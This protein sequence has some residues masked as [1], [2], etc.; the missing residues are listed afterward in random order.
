MQ[1]EGLCS[2]AFVQQNEIHR[3]E[4]ELADVKEKHDRLAKALCRTEVYALDRGIFACCGRCDCYMREGCTTLC[5]DSDCDASY[6][7]HCAAKVLKECICERSYCSA[8]I[9]VPNYSYCFDLHQRQCKILKSQEF[10]K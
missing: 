1:F 7:N 4:A 3:L 8:K 5:A 6:C 2:L 9:S 10:E